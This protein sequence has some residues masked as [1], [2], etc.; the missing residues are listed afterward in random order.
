[1]TDEPYHEYRI[2]PHGEGWTLYRNGWGIGYTF[3][4]KS[5]AEQA[6]IALNNA[7][8]LDYANVAPDAV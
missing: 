3:K 1:M 6:L 2:E 4:S 7:I 5:R 8:A